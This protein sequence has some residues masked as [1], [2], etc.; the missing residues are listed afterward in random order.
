[1]ER[2]YEV[3][4]MILDISQKIY[5]VQERFNASAIFKEKR[6]KIDTK[7]GK[8]VISVKPNYEE[9]DS[10]YFF[11][12]PQIRGVIIK[13]EGGDHCVKACVKYTNAN[14]LVFWFAKIRI[15][16]IYDEDIKIMGA[17]GGSWEQPDYED[18]NLIINFNSETPFALN[19]MK[20][21]LVDIY[22]ALCENKESSYELYEPQWVKELKK[23]NK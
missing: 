1:M 6:F 18:E 15:E 23:Y 14:N 11:E 19:S 9:K 21:S 16:K 17:F 20:N 13:R 7:D 2:I 22:N 5:E 12:T 10:S 3:A 8:E 4:N